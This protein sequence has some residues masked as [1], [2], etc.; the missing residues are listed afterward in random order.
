ML[1]NRLD[2]RDW[3]RSRCVLGG[4]TALVKLRHGVVYA[5]CPLKCVAGFSWTARLTIEP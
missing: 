1:P 5:S 2:Q 3:G 4:N